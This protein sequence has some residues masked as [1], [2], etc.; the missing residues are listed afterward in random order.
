[1]K[2]KRETFDWFVS[3]AVHWAG[4]DSVLTR[5]LRTAVL[6]RTVNTSGTVKGI[7]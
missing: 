4:Q 3:K 7:D 2:L 5:T 6:S 1:M